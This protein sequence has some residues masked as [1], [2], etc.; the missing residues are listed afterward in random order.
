MAGA[1]TRIAFSFE[2]ARTFVLQQQ[3]SYWLDFL[4]GTLIFRYDAAYNYDTL[5]GFFLLIIH[6]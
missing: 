2:G 6:F 5:V 3:L 1:E 4:L